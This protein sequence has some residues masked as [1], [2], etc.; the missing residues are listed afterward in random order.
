MPQV[1]AAFSTDFYIDADV[2]MAAIASE[3]LFN[4][5]HC[6][7]GVKVDLI[8]RKSSEYRVFEFSS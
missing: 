3:T 8:V 4:L 5:M 2:A 7:S 6:G 1:V